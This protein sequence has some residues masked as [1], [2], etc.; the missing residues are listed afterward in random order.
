MLQ[1]V[2][3]AKSSKQ[4]QAPVVVPVHLLRAAYGPG[5]YRLDVGAVWVGSMPWL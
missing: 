1:R 5:R 3:Q 2:I 4:E